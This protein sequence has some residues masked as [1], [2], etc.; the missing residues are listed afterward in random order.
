MSSSSPE[1]L[2]S[3]LTES[4]KKKKLEIL[5]EGIKSA[6]ETSF[7]DR[8]KEIQKTPQGQRNI[9]A[10]RRLGL[11]I[12]L[13]GIDM[14][15]IAGDVAEVGVIGAKAAGTLSKTEKLK[16]AAHAYSKSSLENAKNKYD[17]TPD[18]SLTET[19]AIEAVSAPF[20][21][22]TGGVLPSYAI[23]TLRQFH[24]DVVKG[25]F[26]GTTSTLGYLFTGDRKYYEKLK[27]HSAELD[28]A[29]KE[30]A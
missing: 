5:S 30:F 8:W 20:E 14:I 18:I 7:Q 28:A 11:N 13:V 21:A 10:A 17:L 9:D 6:R 4:E 19:V 25:N 23:N 1:L 15:P 22:A 26:E 29:S 24:A 12:S 2:H 16:R 27:Q 3:K